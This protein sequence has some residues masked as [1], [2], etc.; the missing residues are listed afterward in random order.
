MYESSKTILQ[1]FDLLGEED[2]IAY[3]VFDTNVYEMFPL[4]IKGANT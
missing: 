2:R 4:S 1:L 3:I